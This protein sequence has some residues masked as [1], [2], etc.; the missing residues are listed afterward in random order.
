MDKINKYKRQII[1][2]GVLFLVIGI[3][4]MTYSF[5]VLGLN[6]SII[7]TS[8]NTSYENREPGSWRVEKSAKWISRNTARITFDVDTISMSEYEYSDVI[9]LLDVSSSMS[10]EKITALKEAVSSGIE[11]VL[12]NEN[13]RVGV[14]TFGTTSQIVSNLTNQKDILLDEINQLEMLGN[15]N[16][17]QALVNLD[18]VLQGYQK[19]ENRDLVVLFITDGLPDKDTPNQVAEYNYLKSEYPY[20]T[21]Q[22]IQYEMGSGILDPIKEVSDTQTIAT[23]ETLSSVID[24]FCMTS[25]Y[26]DNFEIIDYIDNNYFDL[27]SL[28]DINSSIGEVKIDEE[29]GLQKVIW[30]ISNLRSGGHVKLTIDIKLKEEYQ[31]VPGI[32]S[33]NEQE[34]V[35]SSINGIDERVSSME[36]PR[37]SNTYEVIYDGNAPEGCSVE[38]VPEA[39]VYFVFDTVSISEEEVSCSG[40]QFKGWEVVTDNVTKVNKDYFIMPESDVVIRA[41][42]SKLTISKSMDGVVSEQ[43]DPIMKGSSWWPSTLDKT[44]VTSI[45][46]KDNTDIPDNI[47]EWWDASV[48]QDQSVIAYIEDD[49]SGGYK[50]TIGGRGGIIANQTSDQLFM[51]F[52][53]MQTIDLT[54][55]DT[56]RVTRMGQM[57]QGCSNLTSLDLSN[58]DTSKVT[59]M[60][61]MFNSCYAVNIDFGKNFDV[62]KVTNMLAMFYNSNRL[63]TLN[64]SDWDTSNVTDMSYMFYGCRGLISL[65]IAKFN[66][67][68]VTNMS[69]MFFRCNQLTSLDVSQFNTS[70]VTNMS[71]M[72]RDCS[73]LT[74]LDVSNF[75]TS[76]VTNMSEMFRGC[77][78][79]TNLVLTKYG[80]PNYFDTSK[81][82]NMSY[83]FY[84]CNKLETLD[85]SRFNT[86]SVTNMQYMFYHCRSLTS[87]DVSK[88]VTDNVTNMSYMFYN[89]NSLTNLDV[90][91]FKTSN[92]TDMQFMFASCNE[93]TSLDVN[94]FDTSNVVNMQWMFY[95]CISLITLDV[96]KWN[97][98]NVTN[99]YSTFASC[100]ALESITFGENWDTSNVTT[101]RNMFNTCYNL[102]SLDLS[103]FTTP[104]VESVANM[105]SMCDSLTNLDIRNMDFT[106]TEYTGMFSVNGD[107]I[108]ILVKDIEAKDF[109]EE[110]LNEVNRLYN[111]VTI[112]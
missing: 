88:F 15:T 104:K 22:A 53:N 65:N 91:K 36:V 8:Q 75:D 74:S 44:M 59:N 54:H 9:F 101:M 23:T 109:I 14:I 48:A 80:L 18:N 10:G 92:V 110:R 7:I 94:G 49:G 13:N 76:N 67:V 50:V 108:T 100:R 55:L 103:M 83:M 28:Q 5:A 70:K 57:F 26:Y 41:K 102:T 29:N 61:Y 90:S 11:K 84:D 1:S 98:S 56:S 79:L 95:N 71:S 78:G 12:D 21:I 93:L 87:L 37:I 60:S 30:T 96:S 86:S 20:L 46:T 51:N 2:L 58:F 73:S 97:T 111:S 81:V 33:T 112:V 64:L 72:F 62:S 106:M 69:N 4:L 16:Y 68:K 42:W 47:I 38:N 89:C 6:S 52:S 24:N 107:A 34:Q 27:S 35:I 45:T 63:I 19:E 25:T 99:L 17:Y 66:T 85:V 31:D 82:T 32:Y 40:Y 39:E 105:F 43:G 77:T 3:S